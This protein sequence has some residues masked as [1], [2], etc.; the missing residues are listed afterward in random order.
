MLKPAIGVAEMQEKT[1]HPLRYPYSIN[2]RKPTFTIIF[3]RL[4]TPSQIHIQSFRNPPRKH[5]R[6][7]SEPGLCKSNTPRYATIPGIAS[8][9][10]S[11]MRHLVFHVILLIFSLHLRLAGP[12]LL[13]RFGVL[14][15]LALNLIV[16]TLTL[17]RAFLLK[18]C[19]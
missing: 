3:R 16:D 12:L 4:E 6:D 5:R 8:T 11:N 15:S 14:D 2:A 17:R 19:I 13:L 1:S 10:S 7:L 9:D 18:S